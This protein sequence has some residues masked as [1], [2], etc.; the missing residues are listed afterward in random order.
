MIWRKRER[1][2][3]RV[4]LSVSNQIESERSSTSP[5]HHKFLSSILLRAYVVKR[6]KKLTRCG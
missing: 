3:S 1:K 4:V 6:D 5:F 2:K